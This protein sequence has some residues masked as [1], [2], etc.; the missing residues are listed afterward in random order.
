[1]MKAITVGQNDI[2][3]DK[4]GIESKTIGLIQQSIYV[5]VIFKSRSETI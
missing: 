4:I 3:L 2:Y 5:I 1:M